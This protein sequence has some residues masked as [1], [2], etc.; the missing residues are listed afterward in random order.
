MT[1]NLYEVG[2]CVRDGLLGIASKD[3]DFSVEITDVVW[4]ATLPDDKV[5]QA[6]TMMRAFLEDN[7][8]VI[9]LETPEHGTIRAR[10]PA[11]SPHQKMTADFVL[12]RKDGPSSDGRRP[13]WVEVG[14][15]TDDLARRDFTVNALAR[16]WDIN[17]FEP[18]GLII[19]NHDGGWDLEIRRLRF[20]GDPMTRLR[21]DG[22]RALR[23][24]RFMI[25]KDFQMSA[26]TRAAI[27]DP[28]TATLLSGVSVERRRDEL[29]KCFKHNTLRTMEFLSH[30]LPVETLEAIF[31]GNL[32]LAATMRLDEVRRPGQ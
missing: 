22:L 18:K 12:C 16:P 14:T 31:T 3:I 17:T 32:R 7:G 15:L 20:V 1:I 10:F 8:F 6:F 24:I 11:G 28:E 5:K 23:A 2:G 29:E 25:T 26:H 30:E 4:T 21:E 9:F 19:D 27:C 13:D